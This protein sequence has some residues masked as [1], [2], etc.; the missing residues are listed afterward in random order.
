[1]HDALNK[2]VE[3]VDARRLRCKR[4]VCGAPHQEKGGRHQSWREM[5]D[6]S[7]ECSSDAGWDGPRRE[8]NKQWGE[9]K[10]DMK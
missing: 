1:V 4:P 10:P 8:T 2:T 9:K 5:R 3:V 7:K 6:C